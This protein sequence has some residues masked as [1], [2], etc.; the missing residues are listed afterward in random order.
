MDWYKGTTS[1]GMME[2]DQLGCCTISSKGHDIQ[3]CS[4]NTYGLATITDAQVIQYY[5]AWDGYV[6]GDP[7]TDNGGDILTVLQDWH[8]QE[9]AG[10]KLLAYTSVDP[11]NDEHVK[12]AI[13]LFGTIDLGLQLP[14]TA[15]AQVGGVWDVVGDPNS[16]PN[17]QP[18]SWGGHDV[19][20]GKY[21]VLSDG[22]MFYIITWGQ[23]QAMTARFMTT[24]SDEL[25]ALLLGTWLDHAVYPGGSPSGFDWAQLKADAQLIAD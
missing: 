9:L 16:D 2:N 7:S 13:Q 17:S 5:S 10:H 22:L 8:A 23:V 15:Q 1:W 14:M 25:Y 19:N 11:T 6:P 3:V 21:A 24:Y 12:K 20:C 18:G 4:L